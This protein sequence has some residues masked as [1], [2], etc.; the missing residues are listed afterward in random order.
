MGGGYFRF[1]FKFP[2]EYPVR[3]P[4]IRCATPMFHCN[5]DQNG[6]VC[7]GELSEPQPSEN[8]ESVPPRTGSALRTLEAILSL[9]TL[10]FPEQALVSSVA[11]LFLSDRRKH[12]RIAR[13]W[14]V[15][16]A[17]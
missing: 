4:H 15:K 13:E 8:K 10:P 14:T 17:F 6:T 3:P 7:L 16:H 5:I 12:D 1:M 9:L 11:K 2:P